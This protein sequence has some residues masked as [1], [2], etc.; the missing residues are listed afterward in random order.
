V[1]AGAEVD[2]REDGS[3]DLDDD[4]LQSLDIVLVSLHTHFDLPRTLQTERVVRAISHP[5]VD[6]FAHP[7]GRLI[8]ERRGADFDL[9]RIAAGAVDHGVIL[10]VNAQPSRLDLDD[11]ACRAVIARGARIAI[12]TDAH[13]R[14]ELGHMRWGVDQARRGWAG[15]NDVVNTRPLRSLLKLLH[16]AR[17]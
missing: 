1:L 8:G 5:A 14:E 11:V 15:K 10:E 16:R 3:L 12:S 9:E 2:I 4:T 6:V 7:T 13:S 17:N